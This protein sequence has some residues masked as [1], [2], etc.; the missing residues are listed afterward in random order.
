M[1]AASAASAAAAS[2][3]IAPSEEVAGVEV[4]EHQIGVGDGGRPPSPPVADRPPDRRP[5]SRGPPSGDPSRRCGRS[6]RPPRSD[7]DHLDHRHPDRQARP[8]LEPVAA[9]HLEVVGDQRL[10]PPRPRSAWRWCPP[11]SNDSSESRPMAAP[12]EAAARAPAAGPD[13]SSRIGN[14]RQVSRG[15]RPAAGQHHEQPALETHPL[16]TA[17]QTGQVTL[18]QRL[19]VDVGDGGGR[20]FELSD[21]GDHLRGQRHPQVRGGP[22][23][24][25]SGPP[26]GVG[27]GEGNAGSRPP[28]PPPPP[29]PAPRPGAPHALRRALYA[30]CRRPGCVPAPRSGDGAAPA[31]REARDRDRTARSGAPVRSRSNPGIRKW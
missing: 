13:S 20:P 16:Q 14:R 5:P 4:S 15:G 1:L 24:G 10:A 28:P 29:R 23:H 8:F 30:C 19:D 22:L 9:V 6:N 27:V 21:L 2:R 25:G 18:D 31:A 17:P 7:L 26:L 12:T 3:C 11:M